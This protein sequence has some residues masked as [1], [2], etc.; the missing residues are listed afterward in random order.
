[1]EN[2]NVLSK[3]EIKEIKEGLMGRKNQIIKDLKNIS[4]KENTDSDEDFKASF[5]EYGDKDDENAQ[6]INEYSTNLATEQVLEKTIK[7]INF[8]L[9]RI[10][11]GSYGVCKYCGE[12]IGKKRMQARPVASSCV[13]C[14]T[15]IQESA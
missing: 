5:P 4:E 10:E 14:K 9:A 6:E 13:A 1:M 7:D 3:E 8:A 15:K 12:E 11:G 2:N